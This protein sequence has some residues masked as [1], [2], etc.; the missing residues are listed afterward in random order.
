MSTPNVGYGFV[1]CSH[2]D[3]KRSHVFIDCTKSWS[4]P[5]YVRCE[6]CAKLPA[7]KPVEIPDGWELVPEGEPVP[8]GFQWLHVTLGST[9]E[10]QEWH[11]HPTGYADFKN[12]IAAIYGNPMGAFIRR[13]PVQPTVEPSKPAVDWSKPLATIGGDAVEFVRT[14]NG[15]PYNRLCIRRKADGHET[16]VVCN[17]DGNP[18]SIINAPERIERDVWLNVYR[19]GEHFGYDSKK[20]ADNMAAPHRLACIKLSIDCAIGEGL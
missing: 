1:P 13:K 15:H 19:H 7:R 12:A 17:D 11:G 4:V 18:W 6:D 2:D 20:Q 14:I 5:C 16:A 8:E 10:G 3:P 9:A